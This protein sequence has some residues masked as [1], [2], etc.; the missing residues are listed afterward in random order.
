MRLPL[1][2]DENVVAHTVSYTK[3]RVVILCPILPYD[4]NFI[5]MSPLRTLSN[6]AFIDNVYVRLFQAEWFSITPESWQL[7]DQRNNY[8]RLYMHTANG[9][10]IESEQGVL[11]LDCQALYLIPAGVQFNAGSQGELRQF[12]VHFDVLGLHDVVMRELFDRIICLPPAAGL[13]S[14]LQGVLAAHEANSMTDLTLHLQLKAMIYMAIAHYLATISPAQLER[15]RE[16]A[17][18]LEPVLPA[19]RYI[20]DHLSETLPNSMLAQQCFMSESYFIRR[21]RECVGRTP[22]QFIQEQ[23]IKSAAQQLLFTSSSID[24]IATTTG[25]GSRFYLTRVFTRH[26]GVAPAAYRKIV[27]T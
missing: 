20:E 9:A 2:N 16:V 12:Y 3:V 7:S 8:W 21:F 5:I 11:E 24:H 6:A 26:M 23:R 19:I 17:A 14:T 13:Q 22:G 4:F 18:S 25:F 1:L 10:W 27:W 15:T